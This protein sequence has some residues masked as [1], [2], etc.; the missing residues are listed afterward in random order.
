[1]IQGRNAKVVVAFFNL[2]PIIL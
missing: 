1:M 2:G